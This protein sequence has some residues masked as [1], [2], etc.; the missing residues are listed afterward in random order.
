[1]DLRVLF[2][3]PG[4]PRIALSRFAGFCARRRVPVFLRRRLWP[5]LS[6]RLGIARDSV[7]GEW[8]DYASFL[9]LFTRPLPEGSRPLP[10]DDE[11]WLSPAD[12]LLV[13]H[14][15]VAGEGSWN[16]KGSPYG[17]SEL[18]PGLEPAQAEGWH[19]LQIYLAPRDYHRFHAPCDL[20]VIEACTEDGALQPVDPSLIKRSWRVLKSNRRVLLHARTPSG[21]R[22]ALLFVGALNVGGMRFSFD[23]TLGSE[24]WT[25]SRR[26]YDPPPRIAR[27]GELGRF[28]FGSTVVLFSDARRAPL[29]APG[30]RCRAREPLLASPL[31]S[32][33]P[34]AAE[35]ES[36]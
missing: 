27:G 8:S 32:M 23:D 20:E 22:L 17:T 4:V 35:E 21:E 13:A 19:A 2:T 29:P 12:G 11:L 25:N 1:M 7:P 5:A 18:L 33:P 10:E 24:P 36:R 3:L 14:A 26:R 34:S 28:E 6:K 30:E 9:E 31:A 15:K 16:I